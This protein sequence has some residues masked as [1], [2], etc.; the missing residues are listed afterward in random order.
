MDREVLQN[1][2]SY[3]TGPLLNWTLVGVIKALIRDITYRDFDCPIHLEV[4]TT[5]LQSSTC[6]API[7]ILNGHAIL[8]LV[9]N[10]KAKNLGQ[11]TTFNASALCSLALK[12]LGSVGES[13][14]IFLRK[15]Y[16]PSEIFSF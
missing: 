14:E 13:E 10:P 2:I 12:G 4:L 9:A 5:L 1:G 6:P 7:L 15:F 3:F 11:N 8:S 16:I